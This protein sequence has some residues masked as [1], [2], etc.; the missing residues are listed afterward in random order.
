MGDVPGPWR[1][2]QYCVPAETCTA[3]LSDTVAHAP[4]VLEL[5]VPVASRLPG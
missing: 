3:G 5:T 2:I 1:A 4:E